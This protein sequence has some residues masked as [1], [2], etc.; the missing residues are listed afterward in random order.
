MVFNHRLLLLWPTIVYKN[1]SFWKDLNNFSLSTFRYNVCIRP[2]AGICCVKYQACYDQASAYTLASGDMTI[3]KS[4]LDDQCK[5]DYMLIE[6]ETN[7]MNKM[8]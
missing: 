7:K 5:L 4:V 8:N 3:V 2:E 1:V 6:G